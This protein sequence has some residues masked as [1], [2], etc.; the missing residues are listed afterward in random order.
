MHHLS[1]FYRYTTVHTS[2]AVFLIG[3]EKDLIQSDTIYQFK[4]D[5]WSVAKTLNNARS[6]GTSI[7]VGNDVMIVSGRSDR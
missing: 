3:G 7:L 5:L 1:E 4:D 2:D 6:W